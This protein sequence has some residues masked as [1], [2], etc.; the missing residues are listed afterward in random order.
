VLLTH[1]HYRIFEIGNYLGARHW[2]QESRLPRSF[3]QCLAPL[4]G[5][6]V[7]EIEPILL[8]YWTLAFFEFSRVGR[9]S[10][11]PYLPERIIKFGKV[12]ETHEFA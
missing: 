8:F 10:K 7:T 6:V 1:D 4:W 3:G 12:Q 11:S 5:L 2:P 9:F